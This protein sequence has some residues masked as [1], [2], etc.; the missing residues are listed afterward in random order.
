[1]PSRRPK[2][3]AQPYVP[4]DVDRL[5]L[6]AARI[7]RRRAGEWHVQPMSSGNAVKDYTCPGCGGTVAQGTAHVVV[8]PA[9]SIFGDRAVEQRRHWHSGCWRAS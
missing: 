7:E 8:W 2:R 6:G 3:R 5:M 1:M 4:L 9:D